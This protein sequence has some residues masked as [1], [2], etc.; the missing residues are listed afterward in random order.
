MQLRCRHGLSFHMRG[1]DERIMNNAVSLW[2]VVSCI[3]QIAVR[4]SVVTVKAA[5]QTGYA[6]DRSSKNGYQSEQNWGKFPRYC[7]ETED[8]DLV[9]LSVSVPVLR[10]TLKESLQQRCKNWAL[11]AKKYYKQYTLAEEGYL[12]GRKVE[13]GIVQPFAEAILHGHCGVVRNVLDAGVHPN[14]DRDIYGESFWHLAVKTR[15]IDIVQIFLSFPQTD[16]NQLTWFGERALDMFTPKRWFWQM[17]QNPALRA[18]NRSQHQSASEQASVQRDQR[19]MEILLAR[20][21]TFT[22]SHFL[23]HLV[24][25]PGGPELLRLA[26]RNGTYRK[27]STLHQHMEYCIQH[28]SPNVLDVMTQECSDVKS[29]YTGRFIEEVLGNGQRRLR[30]GHVAHAFATYMIQQGFRLN[31]YYSLTE[32]HELAVVLGKMV[33]RPNFYG[34]EVLPEKVWRKW[35][36]LAWLLLERPEMQCVGFEAWRDPE[37]ILKSPLREATIA[38]RWDEVGALLRAGPRR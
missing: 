20:G 10:Q 22:T 6:K 23:G 2:E 3:L 28:L 26:I 29:I 37:M 15:N 7:Y 13:L 18:L 25:R 27:Y 17:T 9:N 30:R 1:C 32:F 8:L 4:S 5:V 21:A 14:K 19:L 35:A 33:P 12:H 11:P 34:S 36:R 16:V 31:I 38:R 24:R